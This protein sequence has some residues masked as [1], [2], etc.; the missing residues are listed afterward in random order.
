MELGAELQVQL[1]PQAF[2][3]FEFGGLYG[4]VV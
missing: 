4:G 1:R 2:L 3:D